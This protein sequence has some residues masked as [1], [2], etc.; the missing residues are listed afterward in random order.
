MIFAEE[1]PET[2]PTAVMSDGCF[3]QVEYAGILRGTD[4]EDEARALV[5]FML[6]ER[7]QEDVPLTMFVFPAIRDA[8]LPS[9][10]VE[11]TAVPGDPATLDAAAIEEN[12]ERWI[13]EWTTTVLR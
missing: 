13:E 10:F 3:R 9:E 12:R 5:D 1:R 6:S 8:D 11:F 4:R 2:A 7:F